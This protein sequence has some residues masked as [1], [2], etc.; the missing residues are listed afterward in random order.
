MSLVG[1]PNQGK[2]RV[3]FWFGIA[4]FLAVLFLALG[5][6]EFQQL[7]HSGNTWQKSGFLSA[8]FTL[9]GVHGLHIA[10][11]LIFMVVFAIQL[12]QNGFTTVVLRRL[13]CLKMYWH[14]LY[15]LWIF[16]FAI[17][18]LIGAK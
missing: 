15:F 3:L 6:N 9:I 4:F 18:Y 16:T 17:V 2:K 1:T 11:G 14:F 8:Y 12:I 5:F 10:I 13:S 7:I